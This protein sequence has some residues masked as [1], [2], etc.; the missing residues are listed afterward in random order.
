MANI[1]LNKDFQQRLAKDINPSD[2]I[3]MTEYLEDKPRKVLVGDLRDFILADKSVITAK[4]DDNAVTTAKILKDAVTEDKILNGAVTKDKILDGAVT[5]D[6]LSQTLQDSL[7][8]TK[9][10]ASAAQTAA[11]AANNAAIEAKTTADTQG[12]SISALAQDLLDENLSRL[13]AEGVLLD[14]ITSLVEAL[15][16]SASEIAALKQ[17]IAD[18][19][20]QLDW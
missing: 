12:E 11:S 16:E 3:T 19:Q 1:R 8:D 13:E 14:S 4:L 15:G 2:N 17:D 7:S 9:T 10:A 20:K 6:K 18:L 5:K